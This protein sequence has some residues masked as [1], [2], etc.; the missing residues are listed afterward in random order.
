M[1]FRRHVLLGVTK[2]KS[3]SQEYLTIESLEDNNVIT[4]ETK[5]STLTRTIQISTDKTNWTS[6]TSS[7]IPPTLATLNT[8]DKLYVKGSNNNYATSTTDYNY[9]NSTKQFNVYGNIMSLIYG[10]NFIERTTLPS[11]YTFCGIFRSSKIVDTSNLILP[12]TTLTT[13]C[14]YWMF[15]D[16]TSLTSAPELPAKTLTN[17]CYTGMFYGCT[18]LTNTPKL[19]ATT[20]ATSCYHTMFKGCTSLKTAPKLGARTMKQTCYFGMFQ[21]C[22]SLTTAPEL[23]ATTLVQGCYQYMFYNCT[24]LNS[25]KCLATNISA[26]KCTQDWVKSVAASG[27]FTKAA[28]MTSWTTG[29][30]GIPSG[31]TVVSE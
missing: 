16:C 2:S 4:F 28:S 19:P 26:T 11:T 14:Y 15:R 21:G 6:Y 12:A 5:K 9:F 20:L 30:G 17:Y 1:I 13:Y 29:T 22:T 10:D 3:Y 31:W 18:S 24:K 27:T 8:G 25:I 7:T 23:P